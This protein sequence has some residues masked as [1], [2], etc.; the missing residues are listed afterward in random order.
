MKKKAIAYGFTAFLAL[1]IFAAM[2]PNAAAQQNSP[3]TVDIDHTTPSE[4]LQP[5]VGLV[6][7]PMTVTLKIPPATGCT[8]NIQVEYVAD[9]PPYST[10]VMTPGGNSFV[11]ESEEA[12]P[13]IAPTPDEEVFNPKL[14]VSTSRDAP[15]YATADYEVTVTVKLTPSANCNMDGSSSKQRVQIKNDYFPLIE[16]I[17]QQT[18]LKAGQNSQ[19]RFPIDITNFG[20]GQTRINSDVTYQSTSELDALIPPSS[21]VV[22]SKAQQGTAAKDTKTVYVTARTPHN[23]GYTNSIYSFSADFTGEYAGTKPAGEPTTD[24]Q[25]VFLSLQVQGVYA[26][27]FDPTMLI[28]ALG[29]ALLGMRKLTKVE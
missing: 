8:A 4:L 27:G 22:E 14:V 12:A 25:S 6:E 7:V 26:P 1:A 3:I 11:Y 5:E 15:A 20:N 24:K 13:F 29:V 23:N 21:F 16:A 19:V 10:P 17:P 28:G 18:T 2:I 9:G